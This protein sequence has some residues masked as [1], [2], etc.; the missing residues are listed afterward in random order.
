[1]ECPEKILKVRLRSTE[2]QLTYNICSRGGWHDL[3][4]LHLP[5]FPLAYW[6]SLSTYLN[7][8]TISTYMK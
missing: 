7:F 4:P 5:D 6:C 1:M 2:T 8:N 3:S